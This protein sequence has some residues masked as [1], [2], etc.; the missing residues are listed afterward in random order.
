MAV[1]PDSLELGEE[2]LL[3]LRARPDAVPVAARLRGLLKVAWRRFGFQ[4][5]GL[6]VVVR[7]V[8]NHPMDGTA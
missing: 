2:F 1:D 7:E 6:E 5:E 8:E 3:R 4:C